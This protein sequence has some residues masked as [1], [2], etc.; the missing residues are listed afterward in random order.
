ME[1]KE[2]VFETLSM[3]QNKVIYSR[4]AEI[5]EK[6]GVLRKKGW[7]FS[8]GVAIFT[9]TKKLKSEIF[10]GKKKRKE[11]SVTTRNSN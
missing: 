6:E 9:H 5:A 11:F 2:Q 7:L 8:W 10:N 1:A 3:K 4:I